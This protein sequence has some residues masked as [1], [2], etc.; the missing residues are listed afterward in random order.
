MEP[1]ELE[2]AYAGAWQEWSAGDDAALWDTTVAD[3]L[4]D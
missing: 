2:D 4:T 3:G 1:S